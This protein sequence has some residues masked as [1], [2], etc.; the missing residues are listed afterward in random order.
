MVP[1]KNGHKPV[2]ISRYG[3]KALK[4]SKKKAEY[5]ELEVCENKENWDVPFPPTWVFPNLA[6]SLALASKTS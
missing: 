1:T 6:A 4:E 2:P 5:Q 3:Q